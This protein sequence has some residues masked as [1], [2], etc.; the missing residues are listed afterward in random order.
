MPWYL[1]A[2]VTNN[3]KKEKVRLKN[4]FAGKLTSFFL[5]FS[6]RTMSNLPM[7]RRIAHCF[8][9][10]GNLFENPLLKQRS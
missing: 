6:V 7:F 4:Y 3:K 1:G 8:T 10:C 9:V 2:F 5:F